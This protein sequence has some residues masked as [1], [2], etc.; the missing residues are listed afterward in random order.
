M[1][2]TSVSLAAMPA[3]RSGH[4]NGELQHAAARRNRPSRL[5]ADGS[6]LRYSTRMKNQQ[7]RKGKSKSK[8]KRAAKVAQRQK[9]S[10]AKMFG[11]FAIH[12]VEDDGEDH[13]VV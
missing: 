12:D 7:G 5:V 1:H 6:W 9:R 3:E 11:S 8:G 10:I 13:D 2:L 4:H